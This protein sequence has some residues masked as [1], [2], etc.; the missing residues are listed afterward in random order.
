[1]LLNK[2]VKD[3]SSTTFFV[4][5]K[6]A[7]MLFQKEFLS[8]NKALDTLKSKG[9]ENWGGGGSWEHYFGQWGV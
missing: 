6:E 1:M 3:L 8:S 9:K 2:K 7:S 4:L 5:F